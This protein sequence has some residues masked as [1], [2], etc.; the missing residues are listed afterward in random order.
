MAFNIIQ[1][2]PT[3]S[4]EVGQEVAKA[5]KFGIT[6][7]AGDDRVLSVGN[8]F[9]V[10]GIEVPVEALPSDICI[11]EFQSLIDGFKAE[12]IN[13]QVVNPVFD[14]ENK[15]AVFAFNNNAGFKEAQG[16]VL[17]GTERVGGVRI[18]WEAPNGINVNTIK[19]FSGLVATGILDSGNPGVIIL[20]P[21]GS[22]YDGPNTSIDS[23]RFI[24]T[25]T[26]FEEN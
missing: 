24:R 6:R 2:E 19:S 12:G 22:H 5:A 4:A 15:T 13:I 8:I 1:A 3:T 20:N 16:L 11:D 23:S 18:N 10:R 21:T 26:T 7:E 14:P 25:Y 9:Y 17:K